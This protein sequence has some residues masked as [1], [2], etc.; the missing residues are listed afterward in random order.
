MYGGTFPPKRSDLVI[1][2]I[3]F[4][5]LIYEHVFC[6]CCFRSATDNLTESMISRNIC[7]QENIMRLVF[8]LCPCDMCI[9]C[10]N[11]GHLNMEPKGSVL[12]PLTVAAAC[13]TKIREYG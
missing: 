9:F 3:S 2:F 1:D 6:C 11:I 12:I 5:K 13:G 4:A 8:S 10:P 7:S